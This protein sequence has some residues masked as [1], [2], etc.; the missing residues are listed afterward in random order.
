M[1]TSTSPLRDS[2]KNHLTASSRGRSSVCFLSCLFLSDDSNSFS[3]EPSALWLN[4][5]P[6]LEGSFARGTERADCLGRLGALWIS[7]PRW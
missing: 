3:S 1:I 7:D 4:H 2:L 6:S 5:H